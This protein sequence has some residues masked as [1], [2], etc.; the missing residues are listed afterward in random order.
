[1]FL[2]DR[3]KDDNYS[4]CLSESMNTNYGKYI[5]RGKLKSNE[6]MAKHTSWRAGGVVDEYFEPADL[7]D[8]CHFLADRDPDRPL[9][10]VGLGSNLL[11]RDGGFRGTVIAYSK[12]LNNIQIF[13]DGIVMAEAGVPCAKVARLTANY[14]L[15]GA[16]FFVGIPGS[17]GGALAMNAGAFGGETWNIVAQVKTVNRTGNIKNHLPAAFSIGYRSVQFFAEEWF[18]SAKLKLQP[19]RD[20]NAKKLIK[21]LLTKRTATQPTGQPSCGSVFRNPPNGFAAKLIDQCGLKGKRIGNAAISDKHA[22][23]IINLG[24]ATASDI[25]A[26]IDYTRGVVSEK[27]N[28]NIIPE[29]QIIGERA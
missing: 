18:V 28:V 17:I 10:W 26:L 6:S 2:A 14:G 8:L 3:Y 7:E 16:E 9:L 22:N 4:V 12:G 5:V 11:V 25:E 1:M 24:E 20:N 23:F 21:E 13:D 27:F 15:T 29:V 19:D